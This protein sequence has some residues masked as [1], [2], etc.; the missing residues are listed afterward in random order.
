MPKT[1]QWKQLDRDL[2]RLSYLEEATT[3]VSRPYVGLG[4]ALIFIVVAG[5]LAAL[6]FGGGTSSMIVIAAAVFG[7]YMALNIGANDVANNMGPAV[8]AN[9]LTMGGALLI[10]AVF[11][12]L[13]ALLAGGDV[14]STIS[15]GI[16]DPATVA[17]SR[18]FIWAMMA[19]LVSS[20][21][22]VNLATFVGAPV[23]TTHS[24]VGGVMGAGIAA[25]GFAAV[26]W[27]TM[28]T[29]A[30]SWVISPVLGGVIAAAFLAFIKYRI[31]YQDDKIAAARKWVPVLIGIMAGAFAAYLALKG[32]KKIIDIG[33]GTSLLIGLGLG[34]ATWLAC[35]PLIRRQSEGLEN[36]NR[37]LKVLFGLPLIISAALLSF[38]HGA[39][40]VANAVGPLA[41]IVHT[42][43]FGDAAAKVAI[44]TWVMVIGAVGISFGLFLFG[45]K[46]IRMVGDQITKLNP[47]RAYCVS[48]SA[49]I[50]VIVASWLGLPVSSTHIAVGG[51]FG[52]GF[53]REWE[54]ERRARETALRRSIPPLGPEERRRRKLVRRSHFMTIVAAWVITVPAAALLSG[55]IFL[56][57]TAV[58]A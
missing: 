30:A 53:F 37:S 34:I 48:L 35:I 13:G 45:P 9:A 6:V 14:V 42:T 26:N 22:W 32:L 33:M 15:K 3:F 1:T 24:V 5:L 58:T 29:I 51:V 31:I 16:I 23:S 25:A 47:M 12:S 36:R 11:E 39:N 43:E 57:L 46:L 19:A 20:A 52:V 54:A 2:N 41:A 4:V 21:L 49:A 38:A 18:I 40:D 10:A 28:G 55:V 56:V 7:A 27:P 50:T 17:D 8:G 44:P